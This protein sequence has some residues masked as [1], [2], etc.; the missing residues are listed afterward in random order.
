MSRKS[1]EM[2]DGVQVSIAAPDAARVHV[3]GNFNNWD[4]RATP[5]RRR[6][7]GRWAAVLDLLPGSYEYK[8][9]VDGRWCCAD[10]RD[11]AF[12]GRPGHVRNT[13]G[14]MNIALRVPGLC[15]G[16]LLGLADC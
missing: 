10:G 2:A 9:I 12:D 1:I 15:E 14:T 3:A 7:D 13:Y 6:R 8:F 11:S 16:D 4:P 5:M